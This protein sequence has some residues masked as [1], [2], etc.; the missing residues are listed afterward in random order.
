MNAIESK[1]TEYLI[2]SAVG[3]SVLSLVL[4]IASLIK[5]GNAGRYQSFE[6]KDSL[7]VYVCVFDT[8]TS[9]LFLRT[10]SLEEKQV[11]DLG[12]IDQPAFKLHSVA[13]P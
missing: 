11:I 8:K 12:T 10:S 13:A 9:R 4:S 1:H 7:G 2:F 5:Q 6:M 3:I